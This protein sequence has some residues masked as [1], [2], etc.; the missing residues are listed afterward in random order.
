MATPGEMPAA[1][2]GGGARCEFTGMAGSSPTRPARCLE[3]ICLANPL[4]FTITIPPRRV[5]EE[6][7][8]GLTTDPAKPS[9]TARPRSPARVSPLSFPASLRWSS[10]KRNLC[11]APPP[12]VSLLLGLRGKCC[13]T[14]ASR[15][16]HPAGLAQSLANLLQIPASYSLGKIHKTSTGH[17]TSLEPGGKKIHFL[18]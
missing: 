7:G 1:E 3:F 5:K 6:A 15:A 10:S 9:G 12:G 17:L 2:S 13:R 18:I 8:Y 16:T 14:T 4:V 11:P